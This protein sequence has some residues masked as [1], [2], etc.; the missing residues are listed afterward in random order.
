MTTKKHV[1][2]G[3]SFLPIPEELMFSQ[4]ISWGAV[5]LFGIY[6]KANTEGI[7]WTDEYIAKRM[8]C[9]VKQARR[10]KKE[11]VDNELI[12]VKK[13]P[14]RVDEVNIN[15][16]L[17]MAIQTPDINVQGKAGHKCPGGVDTGCPGSIPIVPKEHSLKKVS[18]EERIK[19]GEKPYFWGKPMWQR[20]EDKKWFVIWGPDDFREFTESQDKIE[21]K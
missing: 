20:P 12:I 13:H 8:R 2:L 3:F 9:S 1:K 5:G 15:F 18:F 7:K 14:G 4:A 16:N 21:F 11:L 17:I 19:N 10:R 6:G